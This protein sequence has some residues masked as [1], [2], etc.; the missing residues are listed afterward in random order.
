[1]VSEGQAKEGGL[2]TAGFMSYRIT[3]GPMGYDVRRK[4]TD[5]AFIRKMLVRTY[6]HVLV[7]PCNCS[8]PSRALPK[9]I[10]K[11]ERYYTRFL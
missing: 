11:K 8:P 4:D 10:D 2:L 6:P 9:A 1:M 3:T 5:F 7:P